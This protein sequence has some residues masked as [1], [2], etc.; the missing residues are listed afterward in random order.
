ML[1][2]FFVGVLESSA[3]FVF[4]IRISRSS[5][6]KLICLFIK[7]TKLGPQDPII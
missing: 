3:P 7:Q 6:G 5:R 4:K 1:N 2:N